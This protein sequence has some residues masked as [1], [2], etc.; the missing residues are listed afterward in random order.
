MIYIIISIV[1]FAIMILF[2]IVSSLIVLKNTKGEAL[3]I[4]QYRTKD[5]R[6]FGKSFAEMFEQKWLKHGNSNTI[7]LSQK[8]KV[9]EADKTTKYN[10][11]CKDIIYA[12]NNEFNPPTDIQFE[13]E[14]FTRQN[15][16]LIGTKQVRGIY[17]KKDILMGSGIQVLR[18]A[19][20]EGTMTFQD[21]CDLGVSAS[22]A[23]KMIIGENCTFKR[24]YAP[25]IFIGHKKGKPLNPKLDNKKIDIKDVKAEIIR[26]IK[27]VD[28]DLAGKNKTL[29]NTIITKYDISVLDGITVEGDIR[30]HKSI[31]IGDNAVIYGNI[32]AEEDIYMGENVRV[33]GHVFT[34]EDFI[35]ER[36]TI[37]GQNGK[38]K[39]IVAR[40]N[41]S[42]DNDCLVYGYVSAEATG[43]IC[44]I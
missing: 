11:A 25:I 13:K 22:S 5:P 15:A 8:D 38:I 31:R 3:P 17:G 42:F 23:S 19:D 44:V 29:P 39:S 6:Y 33:Y 4:Q 40:G 14:I 21:N 12:E 37:V 27:Y 20:A 43:E 2:P 16:S 32:F 26:D 36:G 35:S 7:T 34:Q 41:A 10:K 9:I 24:L 18:W 30:S 28:E 1:V